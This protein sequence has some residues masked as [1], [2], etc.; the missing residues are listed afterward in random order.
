VSPKP[1]SPTLHR[2]SSRSLPAIIVSLLL[3][4]AAALALWIGI[5]RITTRN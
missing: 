5:T 1:T 4:T 2:R 3:L